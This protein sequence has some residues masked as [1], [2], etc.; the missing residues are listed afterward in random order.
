MTIVRANLAEEDVERLSHA[1]QK[2]GDFARGF[3]IS[4]Y[5]GVAE[6]LLE[7]DDPQGWALAV[8]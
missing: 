1:L 7:T 6:L 3:S 8:V 4:Q 2:L 5:R